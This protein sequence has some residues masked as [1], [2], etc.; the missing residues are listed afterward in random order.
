[1]ITLGSDGLPI[2]RRKLNYRIDN[3]ILHKLCTHCGKHLR[4]NYFYPLKYV[5]DGKEHETLQSW[6]KFCMTT[7][8]CKRV[9]ENKE[10]EMA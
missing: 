1:M 4:L 7:E 3:G 2:G 9:K 10:R 5:R 8:N 6:C